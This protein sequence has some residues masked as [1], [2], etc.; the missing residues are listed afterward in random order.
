MFSFTCYGQE[1]IISESDLIGCWT[2]SREEDKINSEIMVYRS[3]NYKEFPPSRYRHRFELKENG[4]CIVLSLASNDSHSM[5]EGTWI[6]KRKKQII[7]I[8]NAKGK[9]INKFRLIEFN[10]NI[11]KL[12]N[13]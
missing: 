13:Y 4:K 11:M 7:V 8:F 5:S 2:H 9:S 3:C 6:Y 10:E 12:K 1:T